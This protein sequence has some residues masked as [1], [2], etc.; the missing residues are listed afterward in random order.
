MATF[1]SVTAP[2]WSKEDERREEESLSPEERQQIY[3]DLF[4][5]QV[6]ASESSNACAFHTDAMVKL[7]EAI[8]NISNS[9]K[10]V[11]LEAMRLNPKLVTR[12]SQL[13][14]FLKHENYNEKAAA[15][16][17]VQYWQLRG[18]IF[19]N[20]AYEA[21]TL[22][23]KGALD[24]QDVNFL[25]AGILQ[26]LPN[27]V[28]DRTVIFYNNSAFENCGFARDCLH[29]C[30]FY[31]LTVALERESTQRN[32]VVFVCNFKVRKTQ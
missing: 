25:R 6:E 23:G 28:H 11:Y 10:I 1:S 16:R 29:R 12:E 14:Y 18:K 19:T 3:S 27:D 13:S 26:F 5:E 21:M 8:E 20:R 17:V 22:S 4:G 31:L 7:V 24:S 30:L 9:H 15:R 32:G 2:S